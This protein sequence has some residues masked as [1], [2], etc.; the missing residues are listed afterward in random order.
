LADVLLDLKDR[1]PGRSVLLALDVP[2]HS[3]LP[4]DEQIL[5]T[6]YVVHLALTLMQLRKA[7]HY[8]R[9]ILVGNASGAIYAALSAAVDEVLAAPGALVQVLPPQAVHR[10]TGQRAASPTVDHLVTSGVAD[11]LIPGAIMRYNTYHQ[12]EAVV[13][14]APHSIALDLGGGAL[15]TYKQLDETVSRF[16]AR[17]LAL[18]LQQGDRVVAQIDKSVE[19]LY[20]YLA[21]LRSGIVFVPL[22]TAYQQSELEHF[23]VDAQPK[24]VVCRSVNVAIF[25]SLAEGKSTLCMT[26]DSDGGGSF[27]EFATS[28]SSRPETA[29]V[30]ADEVAVIIYTSGTTGRS[31]GA[32]V[33]HRNLVS[34]ARTLIDTWQFSSSDVL[35]H[36]LPVFHVHGLFVANHCALFSGARIIWRQKYDPAQVVRDLSRATVFMGVPTFY[37]RLL[38]QKEFDRALCSTMRLFISGS[39]PLLAET[40]RTFEQRSG[41]RILER[42]GMSEA[43]MIASN[44]LLGE[45]RAETVGFPLPG[46]DVRVADRNDQA[47]PAGQPGSIQ[48]RGSNVFAGYWRMPEKSAEEFTADG[49]FRTGDLGR[50]DLRGYLSI[51]GRAKDLIISGG[52]NVYPKEV[53]LLLDEIPGVS[54]SAVIG[55][56]DPDFGEAVTAII[57]LQGTT[58]FDEYAA[59]SLMKQRIANFKVPKRIIVVDELPRNA[60]GK[61]Q[62]AEL[63]SRF[64]AK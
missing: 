55:L 1:Q 16:H 26:L 14:R 25:A 11:R 54:E 56:P 41:H 46:V 19:A 32:M 51:V 8:L 31:K 50:F 33:T 21:C 43:G 6:E 2:G 44:P 53:E 62:K 40:F 57:V 4:R 13:K 47:L 42:Y 30:Q 48:I 18:G 45:R 17:L 24:L 61:V 59:I 38:E 9:L 34:N 60:M 5:L 39:A 52:Y 36:A 3:S 27:I 23:V 22:N 15:V 35:L 10:I 58:A 64:A 49:F 29:H 63:R 7:G 37:T 28:E 20:L 12:I